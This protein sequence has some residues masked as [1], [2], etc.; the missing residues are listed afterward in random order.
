MK[1]CTLTPRRKQQWLD[2]LRS[3]EYQQGRER[4]RAYEVGD[5]SPRYCCL[6][7]LNAVVG[8]LEG[9]SWTSGWLRSF[10]DGSLVRGL[11]EDDQDTLS[12]LNDVDGASFDQ[13]A[14]WIE[15][16]IPAVEG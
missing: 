6:G 10:N 1:T 12:Q 15:A 5:E 14:D 4:L 11:S 16:H 13:I 7:V 8:G 2:A 9:L 3:G